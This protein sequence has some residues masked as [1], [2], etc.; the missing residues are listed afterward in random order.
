MWVKWSIWNEVRRQRLKSFQ[1]NNV[2]DFIRTVA[3]VRVYDDGVCS[4]ESDIFRHFLL[5]KIKSIE[6]YQRMLISISALY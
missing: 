5:M 1:I 2:F 4:V 6:R 3:F